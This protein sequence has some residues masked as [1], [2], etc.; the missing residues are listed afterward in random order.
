[1]TQNDTNTDAGTERE[2]TQTNTG[3]N[4]NTAAYDALT[5]T[6]KNCVDAFLTELETADWNDITH[7]KYDSG[8]SFEFRN[9]V[10]DAAG[11][12]FPT[13]TELLKHNHTA[14]LERA[15]ARSHELS[16][17]TTELESFLDRIAEYHA[18]PEDDPL[19]TNTVVLDPESEITNLSDGKQETITALLDALRTT[20][21]TEVITPNQARRD[22]RSF[23][24]HVAEHTDYSPRLVAKTIDENP[25]VILKRAAELEIDFTNGC[26]PAHLYTDSQLNEIDGITITDTG[27]T[28]TSPDATP[29]P[30]AASENDTEPTPEVDSETVLDDDTTVPKE[31]EFDELDLV[32]VD[33]SDFTPLVDDETRSVNDSETTPHSDKTTSNTDTP[34]TL[35]GKLSTV[36]VDEYIDT[37]CE[38]IPDDVL[39]D[40]F[41]ERA[42]ELYV[43]GVDVNLPREITAENTAIAAV[44]AAIDDTNVPVTRS[45]LSNTVDT[46]SERIAEYRDTLTG[47]AG[48]YINHTPV[49]Q[50]VTAFIDRAVHDLNIP[51]HIEQRAQTLYHGVKTSA[52]NLLQELDPNELAAA[53]LSAAAVVETT[54][55]T[56]T[57]VSNEQIADALDTSLDE[58]RPRVHDIIHE[59]ESILSITVHE[60]ND[61]DESENRITVFN[62]DELSEPEYDESTLPEFTALSDSRQDCID[63]LLTE[64]ETVDWDD[65]TDASYKT[66]LTYD[67]RK[68]VASTAG[69]N[70][71]TLTTTIE[72]N[73]DVIRARADERSLSYDTDALVDLLGIE[74]NNDVPGEQRE[75]VDTDQPT[76]TGVDDPVHRQQ[77][78]RIIVTE[79]VEQT[80]SD[81]AAQGTDET[82]DRSWL[83][84]TA[85]TAGI[86]LA[87]VSIKRVYRRLKTKDSE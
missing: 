77:T 45:E 53:L 51:P 80:A 64:L 81:L 21:E 41:A 52:P 39:P 47:V 63:A 40:T 73:G 67:F 75:A 13:V 49:E 42:R 71:T 27:V 37:I 72:E 61:E 69:R 76:T 19:T 70:P 16:Y 46:P 28:L 66:G 15:H 7:P 87:A 58:I 82:C 18:T 12:S 10:A 4:T 85:I 57:P 5:T 60:L 36:T 24:Q 79:P 86:A 83:R 29:D 30:V 23:R 65:I 8:T 2:Q 20:P 9:T 32:P 22:A 1:M 84:I 59:N 35:H 31:L 38:R 74:D 17:T 25:D 48:I 11:H 34:D 56:G 14:I 54:G 26:H 62:E 6:R 50:R 78:D 3:T 55:D 43:T 33:D 68:T 44:T